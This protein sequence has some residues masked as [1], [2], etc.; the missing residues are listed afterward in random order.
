MH[1]FSPASVVSVKVGRLKMSLTYYIH[2]K[3]SEAHSCTSLKSLTQSHYLELGCNG[4]N[5]K[6]HYSTMFDAFCICAQRGINWRGK[7]CFWPYLRLSRI[8]QRRAAKWFVVSLAIKSFSKHL[9]LSRSKI[10]RSVECRCPAWCIITNATKVSR[11]PM[12]NQ[13]LS[14]NYCMSPLLLKYGLK[15][16]KIT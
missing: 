10:Y 15:K 16:S 2:A 14:H 12:Q 1:V 4:F 6:S 3:K 7:L 9:D 11:F 5:F 8:D 13:R